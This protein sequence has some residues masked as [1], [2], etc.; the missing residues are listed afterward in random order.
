MMGSEMFV[1]KEELLYLFCFLSALVTVVNQRN[2]SS[3]IDFFST[4]SWDCSHFDLLEVVLAIL[5]NRKIPQNVNGI[6]KCETLPLI[7]L[8]LWT[9][10]ASHIPKVPR[11]GGALGSGLQLKLD[12]PPA[13]P[14]PSR[15]RPGHLLTRTW[16][17]FLLH[18]ISLQSKVTCLVHTS[19]VFRI[20]SCWIMVQRWVERTAPVCA[21]ITDVLLDWQ[22]EF[23]A[24]AST[25]ISAGVFMS[26]SSSA[27]VRRELLM[28]VNV[29]S[30]RL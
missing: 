3:P 9:K 14:C 13:W 2:K 25:Q 4:T 1:L 15:P 29:F 11:G 7:D 8:N 23:P 26:S 21:S 20:F 22:L 19:T 27:N 6:N 30:V 28:P 17:C 18:H 24:W 12:V 16:L 10:S 5:C